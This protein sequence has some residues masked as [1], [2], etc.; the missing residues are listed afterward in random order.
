LL[1]AAIWILDRCDEETGERLHLL[2]GSA[3]PTALVATDQSSFRARLSFRCPRCR[4]CD[5][6]VVERGAP[7]WGKIRNWGPRMKDYLAAAEKLRSPGP[8]RAETGD[9]GKGSAIPEESTFASEESRIPTANYSREISS[10]LEID[11]AAA[12]R[13]SMRKCELP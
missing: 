10:I 2:R 5:F 4:A 8:R 13:G 11:C 9:A 1:Q 7:K 6:Y 12:I 3:W